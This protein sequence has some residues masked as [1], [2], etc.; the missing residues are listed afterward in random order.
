MPIRRELTPYPFQKPKA[1]TAPKPNP[2]AT[3]KP[4]GKQN[5]KPDP[6]RGRKLKTDQK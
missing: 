1:K 6:V 3:T 2:K 4:I 5:T